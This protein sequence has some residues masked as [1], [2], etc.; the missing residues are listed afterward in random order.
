MNASYVFAS[1]LKDIYSRD[2]WRTVDDP[3]S[4]CQVPVQEAEPG[5]TYSICGYT[6]NVVSVR[7]LNMKWA[8]AN[9]LH[10]FAGTEEA[11]PLLRYNTHAARFLTG[12]RWVGA[13]G[14]IA[15]PQVVECINLLKRDSNTRRAVVSM[16]DALTQ[17]IN[18]PACWSFLHFLKWRSKLDMMVYQRSLNVHGVMPYDAIVLTNLQRYVA[19]AVNVPVGWIRWTVGSLHTTQGEVKSCI[20]PF[21]RMYFSHELLSSPSACYDTID[22]GFNLEDIIC[23]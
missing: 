7:L 14:A 22:K 6:D 1:M 3:N 10:F 15:M 11:E 8:A 9:A 16:G 21:T 13:Y 12:T 19:Q 23:A 5:Q 18:R 17:D 2:E 20:Q 4:P